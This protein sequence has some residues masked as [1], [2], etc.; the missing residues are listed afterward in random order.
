V[1]LR[2]FSTGL[3]AFLLLLAPVSGWT[4]GEEGEILNAIS[5]H[6]SEDTAWERVEVARLR[7]E[8]GVHLPANAE[9]EVQEELSSRPLGRRNFA[10]VAYS[11]RA[12]Q[13]FRA[14][15][16]VRAYE[17]VYYLA[18]PMAR[19]EIVNASSLV[20]Q[21]MDVTRIPKDAITD[22]AALEGLAASRPISVN[23]VLRGAY[24]KR[25][26][27]SRKGE[28]VLL[29]AH[30]AGVRVAVPGLLVEDGYI[31]RFVRVT[32]IVSGKEVAGWLTS[33]GRVE[34]RF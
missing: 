28:R 7:I 3:L 4:A 1:R 26:P 11:G 33:P 12:S 22:P 24:F 8:P 32:N 23:M 13:A 20:G 34:V 2:T 16:V 27:D 25:V 18:S 21:E 15:A 9:V 5:A 19:G 29:V 17:T 14:S 6:V 10:M 30:T 31:G